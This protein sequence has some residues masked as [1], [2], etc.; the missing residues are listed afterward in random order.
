MFYIRLI[1]YI[2]ISHKFSLKKAFKMVLKETYKPRSFPSMFLFLIIYFHLMFTPFFFY[3]P[4]TYLIIIRVIHFDSF[5]V[6]T[7]SLPA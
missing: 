3:F 6:I 4:E 1:K 5:D 7:V 2:I